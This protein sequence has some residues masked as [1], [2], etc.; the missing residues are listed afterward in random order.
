M[1]R[2]AIPPQHSSLLKLWKTSV[3]QASM[4]IIKNEGERGPQENR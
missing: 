4:L 3:L 2:C 1:V